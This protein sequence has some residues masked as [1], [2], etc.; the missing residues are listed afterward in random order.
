MICYTLKFDSKPVSN[1]FSMEAQTEIDEKIIDFVKGQ[2]ILFDKASR[3][4]KNNAHKDRLWQRLASELGM[5]GRNKIFFHILYR[6]P[7]SNDYELCYYFINVFAFF[8]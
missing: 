7:F 4:Y 8:S 5:E 6:S 2:S 3:S 1:F